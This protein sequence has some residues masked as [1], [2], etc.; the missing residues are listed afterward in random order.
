[1]GGVRR[2]H[3]EVFPHLARRCAEAGWE[4][5]V[6]EGQEPIPFELPDTFRRLPSR[7]PPRPIL[8]RA[9]LEGR[10]IRRRTLEA[11]QSGTPYHLLHT[12]HLPIP[13]ALLVPHSI[14]IHDLRDLE[15]HHT[16]LSR[17]LVA[18][19]IIGR[20]VQQA[21][22]VLTVSEVVRA[23]LIEHFRLPPERIHLVGNAVDHFTPLPR[24][25]DGSRGYLL[26]IGHLEPR[27]NL[28]LLIEALAHDPSLPRLV[29]A[30]APKGQ[31]QVRLEALAQ[32]RGV[33]ERV[34][35]LGPFEDPEL[36]KLYQGAACVV[37]P[38][39]LEGFGIP[40]VEAQFAR[41][42]LAI[43]NQSALLEAAGPDV[44]TF[45]PTD[46]VECAAAIQRALATPEDTLEFR[47]Q[48]AGALRWST[49]ADRWFESWQS[50]LASGP[51]RP[52][53]PRRRA[54]RPR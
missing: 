3:A 54:P 25:G 27:K 35:F 42:P 52:I 9:T 19:G 53:P 23:Q 1:M 41:V 32:S 22:A 37:L 46:P 34:D 21:S 12:G 17:R 8:V 20:A 11:Q 24:S 44:P 39:R 26:H 40:A 18:R 29:L 4:V 50:A 14:T 7:V 45:E 33:R 15:S 30:G 49:V 36:P 47:A 6:L 51:P 5:D 38:S 10:A 28:E 43:S 2:H 48:R 16:P 31:E 13:R